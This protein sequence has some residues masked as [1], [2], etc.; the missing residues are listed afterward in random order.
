MDWDWK[1]LAERAFTPDDQRP[2]VL[3]DGVCNLCDAT[4]NFIMDQDQDAQ[5]RFCSLQSKTG[6]A[7]WVQAGRSPTDMNQIVLVT[8]C[9]TYFS[10]DAVSR[11]CQKLDPLPLKMLGKVGQ[12]TPRALREPIYHFVSKRR[13]VFGRNESCRID[14]DGTFTNRFVSDPLEIA[15]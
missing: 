14:F 15:G 9:K 2:I 11:I 7:L 12:W 3:F 10:S 6:Q 1:S 8:P 13:H 4:I 5:L